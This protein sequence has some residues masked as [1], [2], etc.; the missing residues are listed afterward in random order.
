MTDSDILNDILLA[1]LENDRGFTD[2]IIHEGYPIIAQSPAGNAPLPSMRSGDVRKVTHEDLQTFAGTVHAMSLPNPA[3]ERDKN[4]NDVAL[5]RLDRGAIKEAIDWDLERNGVA[6]TT[7]LRFTIVK[8]GGGKQ[9]AAVV[10]HIPQTIPSLP[11]I[12]FPHPANQ[13][14]KGSGLVL[15]TGPTKNGKSTTAAA[16][17]KHIR[18]TRPGHIVTIEDPIEYA[19]PHSNDGSCLVTSREVGSDVSS[20]LEGAEDALRM[21]PTVI[22]IGE[23][24]DEATARAALT[25]G[26]SGHLVISTMQ[27]TTVE[28]ALFKLWALTANHAGAQASIAS[29]LRGV[30]RTAL[31]PTKDRLRYATAYEF[32]I[33]QGDFATVIAKGNSNDANPARQIRVLL[34]GSRPILGRSLNLSLMDLIKD[35]KITPETA[36]ECSNDLAD[37]NKLNTAT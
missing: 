10:R 14:L 8:S 35:K 24:R 27:S 34:D 21:N 3:Q 15:L 5:T 25:L 13:L 32:M 18:D 20:Y 9:L 6:V 23:I 19:L 11:D 22:M 36:R 33:N 4:W 26:E 17:L 2:V 7:R 30:V 31:I 16:M 37:F 28:G 29:C 1:C 12:D